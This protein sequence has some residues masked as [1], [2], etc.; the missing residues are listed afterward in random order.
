MEQL[1]P[2]RIPEITD[3]DL[4][5]AGPRVRALLVQRYEEIWDR[6]KV[7]I[8][9]DQQ[10][11]RP[12]DPRFLEIGL[13]ALKETSSIYRLGRSAPVVE[14]EEDV[15]S[16]VDRAQLVLEQLSRLEDKHRE[17]AAGS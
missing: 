8:I 17:A 3:E 1:E 5:D 13:R 2:P 14:D 7:R 9:D 15:M 4:N 16:G 11:N 12:L 10:G 6:V